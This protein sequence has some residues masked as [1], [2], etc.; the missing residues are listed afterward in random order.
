MSSRMV[1]RLH[2][3][4]LI[5]FFLVGVFAPTRAHAVLSLV[6]DPVFGSS[7]L[8]WDTETDLEWLRLDN[9]ANP[10]DTWSS[11]VSTINTDPAYDSFHLGTSAEIRTLWDHGNVPAEQPGGYISAAS[12]DGAIAFADLMGGWHSPAGCDS[13]FVSCNIQLL[14]WRSEVQTQASISMLAYSEDPESSNAII[15][16]AASALS[17]AHLRHAWIARVA[18]PEP[19][20]AALQGT[21]LAILSGLSGLSGLARRRRRRHL[22]T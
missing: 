16:S 12:F 22:I 15:A 6:D 14:A 8:L 1:I 18:V 7:S 19:A 2:S 20:I 17:E 11:W 13:T 3:V 10:G 5:A 4:G 9:S 21:A